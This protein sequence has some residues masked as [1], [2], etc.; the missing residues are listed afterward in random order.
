MGMRL[1]PFADRF[2]GLVGC[3]KK[4]Q[5]CDRVVR[6]RHKVDPST[7][8]SLTTCFN[9]KPCINLLCRRKVHKEQ[10]KTKKRNAKIRL[11]VEL[12]VINHSK[13][14]T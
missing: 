6:M 4:E 10:H 5:I 13:Q 12:F 1:Q 8:I 11:N 9:A 3:H 2:H 7:I 14:T